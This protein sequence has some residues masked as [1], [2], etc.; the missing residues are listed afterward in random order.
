MRNKRLFWGLVIALTAA[1][2]LAIRLYDLTDPPLDFH[3]ARQFH[4]A[5]IARGYFEQ[6]RRSVRV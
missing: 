5:I 6:M 3:P 4:S 1:A 2:G